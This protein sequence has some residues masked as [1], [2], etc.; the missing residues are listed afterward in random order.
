MV[1]TP[2]IKKK[3]LNRNS[4]YGEHQLQLQTRSVN[5]ISKCGCSFKCGAS[6]AFPSAVTINRISNSNSFSIALQLRQG[7]Q[8]H[9]HQCKSSPTTTMQ[10]PNENKSMRIKRE[11][12]TNKM[13][14]G[15]NIP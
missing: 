4:N 10:P 1:T 13:Q 6:T 9:N 15:R 14:E 8:P 7:L 12:T 11:A 2:R 3:F 5:R